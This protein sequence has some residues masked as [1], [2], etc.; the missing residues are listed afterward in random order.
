[1]NKDNAQIEYRVNIK[2][3]SNWHGFDCCRIPI[4]VGGPKHEGNKFKA[5]IEWAKKRFKDI[6]IHVGDTLQRH[7]IILQENISQETAYKKS[8]RLGDEWIERNMSTI[9]LLKDD[10]QINWK[11]YRWDD[12]IHRKEFPTYKK[13]I[14]TLMTTCP[15]FKESIEE[16]VAIFWNRKK[17]YF[18]PREKKKFEL[19]ST[20]YLLE[21]S[22]V[23][24]IMFKEKT[25]VDI[26]PGT[27]LL[28]FVKLKDASNLNLPDG[29]SKSKFTRIDFN[30]IKSKTANTA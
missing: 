10:E 12:W 4:S 22:A 19:N 16:Q 23:F 3:K 29:F 14:D 27:F 13:E 1:M 25:A 5:T 15:E 18:S 7:N 20:K 17:D 24:S 11:M 26:Y 21:E 9:N 8:K 2:D 30:R 6:E 28:P